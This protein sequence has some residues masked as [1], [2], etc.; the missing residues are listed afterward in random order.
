MTIIDQIVQSPRMPKYVE[1]LVHILEA[2][3]AA[4]ER[5]YD[6][7]PDDK[8]AEFINGR[9]FVH[10]PVKFE[11]SDASDN[12]LTLLRSYVNRRQLGHVAHEKLLV[13]LTRND[14]EPDIC[15]WRSE[16]SSS[17]ER[18]QMKF[19]APDLAIEILSPSTEA[20]DRQT[21]FEDYAAHGVEEYWI[22]DPYARMIE[23]YLLEGDHYEPAMKSADGT[24]HSRAVKGLEMPVEAAFDADANLKAL[25]R[26]MS[27]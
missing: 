19:P 8:K 7:L 1:Q 12:L 22:V 5:F 17:F 21:K 15:Y 16:K 27:A 24:L 25:G 26:I 6:W 4:R 9:I 18:K 20:H 10:S 23:Q 2:E 11:H 3:R 14:Y 13:C